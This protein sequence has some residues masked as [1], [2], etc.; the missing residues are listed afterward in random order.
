MI[1]Y[2]NYYDIN[3]HCIHTFKNKTNT[4]TN[5]IYMYT[6]LEVYSKSSFGIHPSRHVLWSLHM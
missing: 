3:V 6:M 2:Y 4:K 5:K 1:I